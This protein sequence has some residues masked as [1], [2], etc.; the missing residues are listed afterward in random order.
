[1][2]LLFKFSMSRSKVALTKKVGKVIL[3]VIKDG[4]VPKKNQLY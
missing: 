2:G 1:M 4:M 3:G